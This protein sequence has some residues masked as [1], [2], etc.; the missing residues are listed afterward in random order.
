VRSAEAL[1][2]RPLTRG[3]WR[4]VLPLL[5]AGS[6]QQAVARADGHPLRR[7]LEDI[8]ER[9]PVQGAS[10]VLVEDGEIAW[11]FQWGV[12]DRR[13]SRA[14]APDTVF[15]AGSTSKNLTSLLVLRLVEE[16]QIALDTPIPTKGP[17][18]AIENPW[19]ASD[20]IRLVHLLEHTAGL[21]GS[22]Y[23]DYAAEA[24]DA[25]PSDYL[26]HASPIL[27][28]WRP[29]AFHSY[30][31]GGH[32]IA[33]WVTEQVTGRGFDDLMEELVFRPL[34]MTSASFRTHDTA[35]ERMAR[36]YAVDGR[37]I[38]V[39]QMLMRPSGSLRLSAG[40]LAKLVQ[41]YLRDG[42]GPDGRRLLSA[43]LVRR[44]ERGETSLAARAGM[45]E[46][47][48]GLGNF[49][50][51]AAGRM[52]R[53]HWGRTE[54]FLTNWGYLPGS[55]LGFVLLLNTSDRATM[56]RLRDAIAGHLTRELPPPSAVEVGDGGVDLEAEGHYV[57]ATHD[58]PLRA[59][60]FKA[61][62][63]RRIRVEPGALTVDASGP[64]GFATW[65]YRPARGGGYVSGAVSAQVSGALVREGGQIYWVDGDAFV[66]VS[67][68]EAIG[69]RWLVI[70]AVCLAVVLPIYSL[71]WL[72]MRLRRRSWPRAAEVWLRGTLALSSAGYLVTAPLFV[73][74]GLFGDTGE[75]ALL[76]RVSALSL[77]LSVA[78]VVAAA[79]AIASLGLTAV[80]GARLSFGMRLVAWISSLTLTAL[81]VIWIANGW[82]PLTTWRP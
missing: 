62:D 35:T 28:R 8:L 78:S 49:G 57:N 9:S 73:R 25:A 13:T 82:V 5:L 74:F 65:T 47:S 2:R 26:R 3:V 53:G 15:R 17:V 10:V 69:R 4:L 48:Y 44:M 34:A 6:L 37:E 56:T 12:E 32:T 18:L 29:G 80:A 75:L 43:E 11:S 50:F 19:Q 46:G 27:L 58:M 22:C 60:L 1:T 79:S 23:P 52:F 76:G 70:A 14:V 51:A 45:Q 55:G 36:S 67:A 38:P 61:L 41:F 63:Q 7:T 39:W 64:D 77:T 40:D 30:A 21:P 42:V 81:G 20:P 59:W 33:A 66:K 68:A 16:G 24:A 31:N 72:A 71:G 54:G